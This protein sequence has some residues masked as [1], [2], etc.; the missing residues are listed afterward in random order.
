M[1]KLR[2]NCFWVFKNKLEFMCAFQ[3]KKAD[4][5]RVHPQQDKNKIKI[6]EMDI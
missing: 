1:F 3:N 5:H 4:D 6:D 2:I